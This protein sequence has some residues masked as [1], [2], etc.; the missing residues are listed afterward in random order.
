MPYGLK[1]EAAVVLQVLATEV[2]LAEGR[3]IRSD[4]ADPIV[5]FDDDVDN[6]L[7]SRFGP[8]VLCGVGCCRLRLQ[9][10]QSKGNT[11]ESSVGEAG[12]SLA[13]QWTFN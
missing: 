4:H 9:L 11:P 2:L 13:L 10:L 8:P 6:K 3:A 1:L 12:L 5:R 7:G